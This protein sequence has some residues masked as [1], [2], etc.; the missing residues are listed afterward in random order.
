[1]KTYETLKR[2]IASEKT[3]NLKIF[4]TSKKFMQGC[5]AAWKKYQVY[6]I[7]ICK[8][9]NR[10]DRYTKNSYQVIYGEVW[11]PLVLHI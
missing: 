10:V 3:F 7:E 5:S 6:I 1:M 11:N 4:G 8:F 2:P 9:R